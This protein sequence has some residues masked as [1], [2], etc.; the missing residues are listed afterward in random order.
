MLPCNPG[1]PRNT[2]CPPRVIK[3]PTPPPNHGLPL[4]FGGELKG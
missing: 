3:N 4:M 1:Y 2:F